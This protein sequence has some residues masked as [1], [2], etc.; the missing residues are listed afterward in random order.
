VIWIDAHADIN[1][2]S[3][4]NSKALHGM[5]VS[6]LMGMCDKDLAF[7]SGEKKPVISPEHIIYFGL[8]DVDDGEWEYMHDLNI[9]HFSV[10]EAR[11]GNIG[12]LI[13]EA[14]E[15]LRQKTDYLALS[16]DIDGFDPSEVSATG[17]KVEGGFT[18]DEMFPVLKN[19]ANLY[20]FSLIEIAEYNPALEGKDK[21]MEFTRDLLE[22]ILT[23]N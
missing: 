8:R 22:I 10:N 20:D 9:K 19:I 3:T 4:S 16:I 21:T 14:I 23:D 2:F 5:P 15:E 18:S 17:S 13:N 6:F 12:T 7:M 11:E 1:T